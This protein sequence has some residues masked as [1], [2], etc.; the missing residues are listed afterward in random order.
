MQTTD[1]VLPCAMGDTCVRRLIYE[2]VA[3][4]KHHVM[5][6]HAIL[7]INIY[8]YIYIR[9]KHMYVENSDSSLY[10]CVVR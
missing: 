9:I 7:Y 5:D 4:K 3:T 1:I 6:I 2:S 10:A 8:I